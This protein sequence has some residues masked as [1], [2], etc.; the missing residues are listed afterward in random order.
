MSD[1]VILKFT[2]S[3][4]NAIIVRKLMVLH[5]IRKQTKRSKK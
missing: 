3:S 5:A 4:K 2:E 1:N